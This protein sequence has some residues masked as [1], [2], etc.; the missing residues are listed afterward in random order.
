MY[1][2]K[3]GET[4]VLEKT[5]ISLGQGRGSGIQV[6]RAERGRQLPCQDVMS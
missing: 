2:E 4:G 6:S 3:Y 1:I 5:T